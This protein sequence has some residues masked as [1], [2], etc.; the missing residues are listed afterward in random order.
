MVSDKIV[1]NSILLKITES[2]NTAQNSKSTSK[3]STA[4]IKK[5]FLEF[6][7]LGINCQTSAINNLNNHIKYNDESY[8]TLFFENIGTARDAVN[9]AYEISIEY[10]DM[11]NLSAL[12]EKILNI[13]DDILNDEYALLTIGDIFK[14]TL[15]YYESIS[16][17]SKSWLY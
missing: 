11:N 10:S 3:K 13:Y 14:E 16:S 4:E 2:T 5:V 12:L 7:E 6:I 15:S 17:I 1:N 9:S 8:K